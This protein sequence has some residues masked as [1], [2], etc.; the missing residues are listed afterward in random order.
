MK[1]G[2]GILGPAVGLNSLV[3]SAADCC[4]DIGAFLE[5]DPLHISTENIDYA[6]I[7]VLVLRDF[8]NTGDIPPC[9]HFPTQSRHTSL[10]FSVTSLSE[11]DVFH[12]SSLP[13]NR[14]ECSSAK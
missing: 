9:R 4:P 1:C 5:L 6:N 3:Y 13:N 8:F 14:R 7:V 11:S 12:V 2:R 10:N